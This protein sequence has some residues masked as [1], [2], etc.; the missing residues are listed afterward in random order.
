[1][2]SRLQGFSVLVLMALALAGP[3]TA[4]AQ[5]PFF[6]PTGAVERAN[7]PKY[8]VSAQR[9]RMDPRALQGARI[10]IPLPDGTLWAV[11]ERLDTRRAGEIVW[12]GHV[13]DNPGDT[14]ILTVKGTSAAGMLQ[15]GDRMYRI[16]GRRG[17]GLW[18]YELDLQSLPS[19]DPV[20]MPDGSSTAVAA[21][22]TP[23]VT[24]DGTVRQDLLVVYNDAGCAA[25]GSCAQL[26]SEISVAVAD[27]NKAYVD[28][29]IGITMSLVGT[30]RVSYTGTLLSP[31]LSALQSTTDGQMDDVHALRNSVG[32][33]LVAMVYSGEGC[34]IGYLPASATSAF[35]VTDRSCLVGNRTMAHEIGHNQGAHHDRATV[36]TSS[37]TTYNYGFRR[38]NDTSADNLGAPYFRTI[39]AYSCNGSPRVGYFS[40]PAVLYSGVPT[41]VDPAVNPSRGAF[42]AR[43]LNDSAATVASFR[44][45]PVTTPPLAPD[46]LVATANGY[47]A[48]G[49]AWADR[50][51]DEDA[52][53]VQRSA[54]G[55]TN[56]S[57]R[58]TLPAGSTAWVDSGLLPQTTYYYR[59]LAQNAA[60]NA[61]SAV[62]SATTL[63][64]PLVVED[65]AKSETRISGTV[66]GSYLLTHAL[67]G[68][69]ESITE[70]A[71]GGSRQ[72]RQQAYAHA[73]NFDVYG[74]QGGVTVTLAGRISGSEGAVFTYSTD[75]GLTRLPMFVI[76]STTWQTR[77][78]TFP[79]GTRGPLRIEVRDA[80]AVGGEPVDSV[81]VD[82][83][84]V[85]S[86]TQAVS[87]PTAPASVTASAG[88]GGVTVAF[89][90]RA[91]NELGFEVRRGSPTLADCAS[92]TVV[93]TL[94]ASA[95]TGLDVSF[96]DAS[97]Q[98]ATTYAYRVAAFNGGGAGCSVDATV[99]TAATPI[100]LSATARKVKGVAFA[101]LSWTGA[102]GSVDVYRDGVFR[103][104]VGG[105]T[106]S[107]NLGKVVG[108]FRYKVC[109][110]G[111]QSCSAERSV[112]F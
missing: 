65:I 76:D 95:G 53:L 46:S 55:S 80:S 72:S 21:S 96:V 82:R 112:V 107:D 90:D 47:D 99:T 28:S 26:E 60:G 100:N 71:S 27:M 49:L 75:G 77:S 34:G 97:A 78:F 42:N 9:V 11:R 33:D 62:A 29:Q 23:Q 22:T 1:M 74:G 54:D 91:D 104:T 36:G 106:Y 58:A 51:S 18:L 15:R 16:G 12:T 83:I 52:Y 24:A 39:L 35:S 25:A 66:T 32:A 8:T 59:V 40:N 94:G 108:T 17:G 81:F 70:V 48:I 38:C 102:T 2:K 10:A 67:D 89:N 41:G 73:W 4:L 45:P 86:S 93:G 7:V 3:R 6:V 85:S 79:V 44:T 64:V 103:I 98:A 50:A 20:A 63:P 43:V 19:D 37:T 61:A 110:T 109:T 101:D 69:A 13:Q 31:A 57:T 92:G 5:L 68:S 87:P 105:S 56:W 111:T 14:V 84:L 88:A 30:A